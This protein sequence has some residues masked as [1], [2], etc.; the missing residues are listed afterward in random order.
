MELPTQVKL[1]TQDIANVLLIHIAG[2]VDSL[3]AKPFEDRLLPLLHGCTGELQK[4]L[5]DLS[6]VHYM[7]SAG[8]R[9]LMLAL[10]QCQKQ[11]GAI[12]LA[13]LQPFLQDVF[14]ITRFDTL[15]QV[16]ATV[17]EALEHLSPTAAST[18]DGAA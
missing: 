17:Q 10:R 13:A 7:N 14:K 5:L 3:T 11:Q 6:G 18:Y 1:Q 16:F 9:V 4:V 8:L 15:F 12:A 2:R